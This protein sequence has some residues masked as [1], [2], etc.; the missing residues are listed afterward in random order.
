MPSQTPNQSSSGIS[1]RKSK[2]ND[3]GFDAEYN[4]ITKKM[5]KEGK[6]IS[7]SEERKL[8]KIANIDRREYLKRE[9]DFDRARNEKLEALQREK[10]AKEVEECSFTPATNKPRFSEQRD[11]Y[12]FLSDQQRFL[13]NKNMKILQN[14]QEKV[15]KEVEEI[16]SQPKLDSLSM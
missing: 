6:R 7:E 14:K 4:R 15:E 11:L 8:D 1:P 16:R 9:Q 5:A 2:K 12:G 10:R 3:K 13:E